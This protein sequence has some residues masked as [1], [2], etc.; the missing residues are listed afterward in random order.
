MLMVWAHVASCGTTARVLVDSTVWERPD[1]C[2][3]PPTYNIHLH[4][5]GVHLH[6]VGEGHSMFPDDLKGPIQ[7][8]AELWSRA[9]VRKK[10]Q[11]VPVQLSQSK[12]Q[13]LWYCGWDKTTNFIPSLTVWTNNTLHLCVR[14]GHS[15]TSKALATARPLL[16]DSL[17][18]P[19]VAGIE[20]NARY[21]ELD[22]FNYCD[23]ANIAAHEIAHT[24][25]FARKIMK[26]FLFRNYRGRT[27]FRG[28]HTHREWSKRNTTTTKIYD[29]R[30]YPVLHKKDQSHW[31]SQYSLDREL[32]L[33]KYDKRNALG[34]LPLSPVTLAVFEDLGYVVNYACADPISACFAIDDVA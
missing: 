16:Q 14:Y 27:L 6:F 13:M 30:L 15:S 10:E 24:L 31:C 22:L 28:T 20:L 25:G 17:G 5:V 23:Y 11:V 18:L 12:R 9:I 34:R 4:F 21:R 7:A 33:P 32:M 3:D 2:N 8:A 19:L 26:P 29:A 1:T